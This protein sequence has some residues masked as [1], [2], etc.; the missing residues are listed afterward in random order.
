MSISKDISTAEATEELDNAARKHVRRISIESGSSF[1]SGIR[2]LS[3]RRR[4]AM[5][6]IYAFCREVDNIADDPLPL[7]EK[8]RL[9]SDWRQEIT[10]VYNGQASTLTGHALVLVTSVYNLQ[11]CDFLDLIDGMEMDAAETVTKGPD[12]ITLDIYCDRVASAVGRLS[13]RIFGDNGNAAQQVATSLG[14]ALQLT[15]ILRDIAEDA[16]RNRLYIPRNLLIQHNISSRN[17]TKV[18][19]HPNLTNVCKDLTAIA[20]NHYNDAET[21]IAKCSKWHMRPAMLMLQVYRHLLKLLLK[22][23]WE[24]VDL[25]VRVSKPTK[26]WILLRYGLL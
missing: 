4:E 15:N 20:E 18:M 22:R 14:R 13:V 12:M 7:N 16:D 3:A 23:G 17:P 26:I 24:M 9:L 6:A 8:R 25:P 1:L 5:Y 21:A 19:R 11:K 2:V 10:N